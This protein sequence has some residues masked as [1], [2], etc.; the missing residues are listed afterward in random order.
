MRSAKTRWAGAFPVVLVRRP[1]APRTVGAVD[2]DS[3]TI[4]SRRADV[5][6]HGDTVM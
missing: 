4:E 3:R 6:T 2:A 5:A 1:A